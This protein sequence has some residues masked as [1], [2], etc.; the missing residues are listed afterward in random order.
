M[1]EVITNLVINS[2]V[3]A[4]VSLLVA[5][6]LPI[7]SKVGGVFMRISASFIMLT[8]FSAII[9]V[10]ALMGTWFFQILI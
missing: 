10:I 3:I 7:N 1:L 9:Y 6:V 4:F 8:I 5:F 2:M